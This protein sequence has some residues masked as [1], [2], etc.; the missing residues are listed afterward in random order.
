MLSGVLH[1]DERK[2]G[3]WI[4]ALRCAHYGTKVFLRCLINPTR[5]ITGLTSIPQTASLWK[6]TVPQ[7]STAY[8][9]C[10]DPSHFGSVATKSHE[11][12]SWGFEPCRLPFSGNLGRG[13]TQRCKAVYNIRKSQGRYLRRFRHEQHRRMRPRFFS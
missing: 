3:M 9:R 4:W 8:R 11:K 1:S 6:N 12:S 2:C 10:Y 5:Y 13:R 7:T